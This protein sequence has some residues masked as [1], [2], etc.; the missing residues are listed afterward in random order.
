MSTQPERDAF[1][2]SIKDAMKED[3]VL[4]LVDNGLVEP[5]VLPYHGPYIAKE[6]IIGQMLN[7]GFDLV[8]QGQHIPQRYL[9]VFKK[10]KTEAAPGS[11][12]VRPEQRAEQR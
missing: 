7:Y 9:L 12:P 2:E 3:G 1:V 10:K 6:L 11:G 5:G 4:Y 8:E